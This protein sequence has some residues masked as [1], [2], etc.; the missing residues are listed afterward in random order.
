M[1]EITSLDSRIPI[2]RARP[3]AQWATAPN[4]PIDAKSSGDL[5]DGRHPSQRFG[6][7]RRQFYA[8]FT[9]DSIYAAPTTSISDCPGIHV[10]AK[11]ERGGGPYVVSAK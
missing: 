1:N 8:D 11:Q 6:T 10:S 2:S 7:P 3:L 9:L 4:S 5:A